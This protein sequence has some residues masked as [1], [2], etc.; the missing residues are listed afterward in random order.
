VSGPDKG[1]VLLRLGPRLAPFGVGQ[2]RRPALLPVTQARVTQ[3]VHQP[4][5]GAY[6]LRPEGNAVNTGPLK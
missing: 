3:H 4:V 2:M 1:A 5:T 6:Y